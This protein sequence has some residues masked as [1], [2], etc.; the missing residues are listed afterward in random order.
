MKLPEHDTITVTADEAR[1]LDATHREF[2]AEMQ[3]L[4]SEQ[5]QA[6]ATVIAG[7]I[8]QRSPL[9]RAL[10]QQIVDVNKLN[11]EAA[12]AEREIAEIDATHRIKGHAPT[13]AQLARKARLEQH[14]E[15][16]RARQV[17][18]MEVSL[19]SARRKT[20]VAW[21]EA[22]AR[23]AKE[24]RLAESIARQTAE[25]EQADIDARAAVIVKA[26]RL[27]AGKRQ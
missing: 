7:G 10:A 21:R 23:Q 20:V 4:T 24:A 3:Q 9:V 19:D 6:R 17:G 25:A 12:E 11:R 1:Q 22:A 8:R 27:G 18:L 5:Q 26:K 2:I 16:T 15:Q 14:I 13:D